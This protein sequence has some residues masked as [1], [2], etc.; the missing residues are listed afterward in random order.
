M[1]LCLTMNQH[2][3]MYGALLWVQFQNNSYIHVLR[4]WNKNLSKI[5]C[6]EKKAIVF[7]ILKSLMFETDEKAFN[8]ELLKI[9][10]PQK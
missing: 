7:K 2:F 1:Y 4:N 6:H 8:I 5:H 3:T 10:N 9:L